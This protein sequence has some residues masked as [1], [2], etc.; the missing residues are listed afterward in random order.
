MVLGIFSLTAEC[1]SYRLSIWGCNNCCYSSSMVPRPSTRLSQSGTFIWQSKKIA[2]SSRFWYSFLPALQREAPTCSVIITLYHCCALYSPASKQDLVNC[3][4][5][6]FSNTSIFYSLKCHNIKTSAIE[7]SAP[8]NIQALQVGFS[9]VFRVY[10][11][12]VSSRLRVSQLFVLPPFQRQVCF[13]LRKNCLHLLFA[14]QL[15]SIAMVHG[16][17]SQSV[18]KAS[19][20]PWCKSEH[21]FRRQTVFTFWTRKVWRMIREWLIWEWSYHAGHWSSASR[22]NLQGGRHDKYARYHCEAPSLHHY[23]WSERFPFLCS[24]E[25]RPRSSLNTALSILQRVRWGKA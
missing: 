11:Y 9:T 2:A 24:S 19:N 12:P 6:L 13:M 10:A 16:A 8:W 25:F 20:K 1:Q 21:L 15:L 3:T 4:K 17:W 7:C 5:R 23:S 22:G 14:Q 18:W